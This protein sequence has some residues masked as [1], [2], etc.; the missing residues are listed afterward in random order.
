MQ[1]FGFR[2]ESLLLPGLS[3]LAAS[4]L[5]VWGDRDDQVALAPARQQL[6]DYPGIR[7]EVLGG[8]G[9]L[10][11]FEDPV[12]TARL[13]TEWVDGAGPADRDVAEPTGPGVS[14]AP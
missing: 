10:F 9:H 12:L 4:T 11:P 7:L 2:P 3:S 6:D 14:S 1:P 8:A 13:V 5:V